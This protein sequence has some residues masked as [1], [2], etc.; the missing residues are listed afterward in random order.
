MKTVTMY[1]A[2]DGTTHNTAE[3]CQAHEDGL[4]VGNLVSAYMLTAPGDL[5][6]RAATARRNLARDVLTWAVLGGYL[7]ISELPDTPGE[8]DE[9]PPR[10][11]PPSK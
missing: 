2:S 11:G 3:A 5:S 9:K 4:A 7:E 10:K 1:Q 6:K 8:D